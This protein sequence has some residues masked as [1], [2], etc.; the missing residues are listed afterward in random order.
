MCRR[1]SCAI[2]DVKRDHYATAYAKLIHCGGCPT[3]SQRQLG[4]EGLRQPWK[5]DARTASRQGTGG[6]GM[7]HN[8]NTTLNKT[9]AR[10]GTRPSRQCEVA[11]IH[12]PYPHLIVVRVKQRQRNRPGHRDDPIWYGGSKGPG[13]PSCSHYCCMHTGAGTCHP[14]SLHQEARDMAQPTD[15]TP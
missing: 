6:Q 1:A 7:A 4:C 5:A 11:T 10:R 13:E 9:A 12:T 8:A 2:A 14:P 3:R 15:V